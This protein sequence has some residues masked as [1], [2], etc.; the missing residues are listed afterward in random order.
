MNKIIVF[1]CA[2]IFFCCSPQQRIKR[3]LKKHPELIHKLD[4]TII[5][6]FIT[7]SFYYDTTLKANFFKDT[8]FI[9]KNNIETKFFYNYSTDSLY[10][11]NFVKPDTL[12]KTITIQGKTIEKTN[13]LEGLKYLFY[14]SIVVLLIIGLLK[15][16]KK[17]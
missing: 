6:T 8:I 2:I 9:N 3:L 10:I 14:F 17:K 11:N 5:D 12:I 1:F 4:T 7:R 15:A 13:S 16:T